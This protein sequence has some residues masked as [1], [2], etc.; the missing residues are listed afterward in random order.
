M[1]SAVD[2]EQVIVDEPSEPAEEPAGEPAVEAPTAEPSEPAGE[3]VAEPESLERAITPLSSPASLFQDC[4]AVADQ[5]RALQ[6]YQLLMLHDQELSV[7]DEREAEL[8]SLSTASQYDALVHQQKQLI[9]LDGEIFLY[10]EQL[11]LLPLNDQLEVPIERMESDGERL[12]L[13]GSGRLFL[14]QNEQLQELSIEGSPYIYDFAF[15]ATGEL[16]LTDPWLLS[17]SSDYAPTAYDQERAVEELFFDGHYL[18]LLQE[19]LL[20]MIREDAQVQLELGAPVEMI[21]GHQAAETAWIATAEGFFVHQKGE[22]FEVE[23]PEGSWQDVD[24]EGRLLVQ[25]ETEVC[26]FSIDRPVVLVGLEE[27]PTI[28]AKQELQVLPT[29]SEGLLE[30]RA[31][32]GAIPL[33]VSSAPWQISLDPEGLPVGDQQ[34]RFV[35]YDEE[36]IDVS[37]AGIHIISLPTASWEVDILPIA[38]DYCFFCHAGATATQLETAEQWSNRIEDIIELISDQAMPPAGPYL[39]EEEILLVR[40]WK[41]SGFQ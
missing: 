14:L 22:F 33:E 29:A 23:L 32:V 3:L 26:R 17:L 19:G 9:L 10:G 20:T 21:S 7:L 34:L 39:S 4:F 30:L 27:R 36:T 15:S 24:S 1:Q 13:Y 11:E 5:V 38:E 35:L 41:A 40:G 12:F 31:Y 37:E 25:T 6:P 16:W 2:D 28:S 18:W 8:S